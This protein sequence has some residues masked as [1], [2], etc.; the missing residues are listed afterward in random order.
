MVK[1]ASTDASG[2]ARKKAKASTKKNALTVPSKAVSHSIKGRR[3]YQEDRS[4]ID[5]NFTVK[6]NRFLM[7]NSSEMHLL[8]VFDGHGGSACS[9]FTHTKLPALVKSCLNQGLHPVAAMTNACLACESAW[10]SSKVE[11]GSISSIFPKKNV[12]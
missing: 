2:A 11:T 7:S 8:G 5:L 10:F 4:S 6:R 3:G 9:E 12:F 1:R